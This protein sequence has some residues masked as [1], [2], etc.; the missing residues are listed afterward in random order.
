[1]NLTIKVR[2]NV[3]GNDSERKYQVEM[4]EKNGDSTQKSEGEIPIKLI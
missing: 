1:M 4:N 2:G 3:E